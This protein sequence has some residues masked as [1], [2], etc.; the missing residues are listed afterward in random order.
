MQGAQPSG[1]AAA[2]PVYLSGPYPEIAFTPNNGSHRLER[3]SLK[4]L[5]YHF[6]PDGADPRGISDVSFALARSSFTALT[7]AAS[8]GAPNASSC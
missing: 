1:P 5:T 2:H 4:G 8:C 3:L 6:A 7:G